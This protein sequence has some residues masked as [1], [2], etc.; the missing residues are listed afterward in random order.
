MPEFFRQGFE[1]RENPTILI[2]NNISQLN[3][4]RGLLVDNPT[5]GV[6]KSIHGTLLI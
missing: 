2:A 5:S 6:G 3:D 1:A 4:H